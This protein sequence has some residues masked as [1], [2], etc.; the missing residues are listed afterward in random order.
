VPPLCI[1]EVTFLASA[2]LSKVLHRP[3]VM[4]STGCLDVMVGL[5]L[6]SRFLC[7]RYVS[8]SLW[9]DLRLHGDVGLH[10]LNNSS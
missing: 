9:I 8:K 3:A 1:F 5:E 7:P 10:T 6:F 4:T 2:L